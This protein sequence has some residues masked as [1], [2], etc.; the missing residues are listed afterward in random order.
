MDICRSFGIINTYPSNVIG[1]NQ[2]VPKML[3]GE[4]EERQTDP[5]SMD[6]SGN[7]TNKLKDKAWLPAAL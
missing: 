3:E 6:S 1:I 2:Q 4:R 7:Q 5:R